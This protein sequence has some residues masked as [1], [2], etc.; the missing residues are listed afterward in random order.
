MA[1]GSEERKGGRD[2]DFVFVDE[3]EESVNDFHMH[4][5]LVKEVSLKQKFF[6]GM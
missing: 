2:D 5:N 6:R 4:H 3:D 1:G